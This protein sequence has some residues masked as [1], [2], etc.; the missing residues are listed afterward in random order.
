MNVGL[1]TAQEA[2]VGALH[3]SSLGDGE[4]SGSCVIV[5]PGRASAEDSSGRIATTKRGH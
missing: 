3:L 1:R 5:G 2:L 4:R